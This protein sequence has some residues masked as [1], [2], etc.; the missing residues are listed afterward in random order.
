MATI[1]WS[2]LYSLLTVAALVATAVAANPSATPSSAVAE[3]LNS[4][5]FSGFVK[6]LE[7]ADL[8]QMVHDKLKTGD[9]TL[10]VPTNEALMY[11]IS[12]AVLAF[13]KAPRNKALLRQVLLFHVVS[14]HISA[15]QWDGKHTSLEGSPVE[16]RMD[17][18]AFY[19]ANN[20]VKQYNA[21]TLEEGAVVHSIK[22]LLI[23]PTAESLLVN[24]QSDTDQDGRRILGDAATAAVA[25]PPSAA[26]PP[27]PVD[28]KPVPSMPP[29]V[30]SPPPPP[31][32]P[33]GPPMKPSARFT[34]GVQWISTVGGAM[35]LALLL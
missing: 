10:F 17:A 21:I 13:L 15:F 9:V 12:P 8:L 2:Q 4:A 28:T 19:A 1:R 14:E 18:L 16:L 30:P 26:P 34:S 25:A 32:Y 23:P 33:S 22:G 35:L 31:S 3:Q 5:G 24:I 20:P 29:P 6:L 11:Q 27:P 7:S